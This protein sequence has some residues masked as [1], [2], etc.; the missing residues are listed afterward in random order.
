MKSVAYSSQRNFTGQLDFC[1]WLSDYINLIIYINSI[2]SGS[3]PK[4]KNFTLK[5]LVGLSDYLSR[6][7]GLNP[8]HFH[9]F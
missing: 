4:H 2:I 7:R 9:K 8:R 6:G 1:N 3:N 5:R